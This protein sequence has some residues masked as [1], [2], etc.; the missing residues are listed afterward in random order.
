M[1]DRLPRSPGVVLAAALSAG[2]AL[3]GGAGKAGLIKQTT[4]ELSPDGTSFTTT[5]QHE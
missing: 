3:L 1:L 5:W 2:L 4:S